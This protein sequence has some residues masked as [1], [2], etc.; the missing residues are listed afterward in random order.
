MKNSYFSSVSGLF[1]IACAIWLDLFLTIAI[2]GAA[3]QKVQIRILSPR[4]G[5]EIFLSANE[6]MPAERPIKG[7]VI[8]FTKKEIEDLGLRVEVSIQTVNSYPQGVAAVQG[9][10]V[11]VLRKGYFGGAFHIIKAVLKDRHGNERAST[12]ANVTLIQ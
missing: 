11:W 4:D 5:E 6:P 3:S 8:G 10:G 7:D 1:L 12:A 9:D 2:C